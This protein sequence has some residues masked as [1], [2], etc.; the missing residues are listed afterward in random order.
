MNY[1][2]KESEG[3][4]SPKGVSWTS[5]RSL[6]IPLQYRCRQTLSQMSLRKKGFVSVPSILENQFTLFERGRGL[7]TETTVVD[8]NE[9]RRYRRFVEDTDGGKRQH[10][11]FPA[12]RGR[13]LGVD[14]VV[15]RFVR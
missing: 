6:S 12:R 1:D 14:D 4:A 13:Q 8:A 9:E 5:V 15:V 10:S 7:L 3:S 2:Q 11:S